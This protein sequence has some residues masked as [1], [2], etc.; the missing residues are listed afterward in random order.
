MLKF[1]KRIGGYTLVKN[2]DATTVGLIETIE[3]KR[4]FFDAEFIHAWRPQELRKL[5][6]ELEQE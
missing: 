5:A 4:V 6:D 3:G 2:D 1:L